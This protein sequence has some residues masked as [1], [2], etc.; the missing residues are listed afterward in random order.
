[1]KH[2]SVVTIGLILLCTQ[3]F[4]VE[5]SGS[6]GGDVFEVGGATRVFDV[7][8]YEKEFTPTEVAVYAQLIAP[9]IA[10][11]K[12]KLPRAGRHLEAAFIRGIK[13]RWY[14]VKYKLKEIHDEGASYLVLS[15]QKTQIA[16]NS[17]RV[18]QISQDLFDKLEARDSAYLL[19]H[20]AVISA[21][22]V[23]LVRD[24]SEVRSLAALFMHKN[25]KN[26][27]TKDLVE[28]I[29]TIV[30]EPKS[31]LQEL[32]ALD[33]G[34]SSV[35]ATSAAF[36]DQSTLNDGKTPSSCLDDTN[37]CVFKDVK[38]GVYWGPLSEAKTWS[39]AVKHCQSLNPYGG[40]KDW[41]LPQVN[42]LKELAGQSE[43]A[44]L[45][46]SNSH[47]GTL[48]GAIWSQT[49]YPDDRTRAVSYDLQFK[50]MSNHAKEATGLS[51]RCVRSN[52]DQR[53][54]DVSYNSGGT[55]RIAC[56]GPLDQCAFL[57]TRTGL[58]WSHTTPA[59]RT[60]NTLSMTYE[61][62]TSAC[63]HLNSYGPR[64]FAGQ[65]KWRLPSLAEWKRVVQN[66]YIRFHYQFSSDAIGELNQYFW[67][68]DETAGT[69]RI[70]V[71]ITQ[72][73]RGGNVPQYVEAA[74]RTRNVYNP[75]KQKAESPFDV[76]ADN[77]IGA[78]NSRHDQHHGAPWICVS[79]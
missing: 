32:A 31:K 33:G 36:E 41:R 18:V 28:E 16:V 69:S 77:I 24:G 12:K 35:S 13:P 42:E 60:S 72:N 65:Q 70:F 15:F 25:L 62:A 54:K 53:W 29:L 78:N 74:N 1:M 64:G 4:A 58:T 49:T 52:I 56:T 47:W 48:A 39:E 55:D 76:Y 59:Y 61:G 50:S 43:L 46:D 14:F 73:S 45:Y 38:T 20:E 63:N 57:E 19:M 8:E 34:K 9:Q 68:S 6:H 27:S 5:G 71:G 44:D 66:D 17:G 21:I 51:F 26:F 40:F 22:G 23:D 2:A 30:D 75:V 37:H 67:A 11:L 10:E 3:S 79:N 7:L